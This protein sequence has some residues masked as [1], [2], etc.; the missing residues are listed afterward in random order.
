MNLPAIIL[1]GVALSMDAFAVSI[2]S[3]LAIRRLQLH[4][5]LRIAFWFGAFQAV[6]PVVGWLAGVGFRSLIAGIDHWV[7][8]GLLAVVGGKMVVEAA[9]G[10]PAACARDPQEA[11]S[12]GD[13]TEG[14]EPTDSLDTATLLILALATSLDALAV[15]FSL[16]LLQTTII[17]PALIIGLV[18]FAICF[19]GVYLGDRL[20]AC[21]G[22]WMIL[23]GGLIL[24][25]I[26]LKILLEHQAV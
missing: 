26:G 3:G 19:A 15:G 6:M 16:S 4:H 5:A 25:G 12:V 17:V 2:C 7:A 20:G 22:K 14:K 13:A 10:G 18:T 11:A 21:F 1:L 24:I 8:F 9:R 23:A